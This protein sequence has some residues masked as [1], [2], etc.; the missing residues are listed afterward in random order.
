MRFAV[1]HFAKYSPVEGPPTVAASGGTC[2][3]QRPQEPAGDQLSPRVQQFIRSKGKS[4]M[5]KPYLALHFDKVAPGKVLAI[6][7]GDAAIAVF[8]VDGNHYAVDDL[9]VRC[10][11]P[12]ADG[13][14]RQTVVECGGC[15]WRYDVATG[16]QVSLP[17][18]RLDTYPVRVDAAERTLAV[19][20]PARART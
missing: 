17:A 10:G 14:L 11:S 18:I 7:F 1:G 6:A 5:T 19:L 3:P 9:C 15:G 4:G 16:A 8:N 20:L 12:L 13:L 2:L